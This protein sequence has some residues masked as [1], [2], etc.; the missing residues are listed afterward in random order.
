MFK[1]FD[2]LDKK[3]FLILAI[4]DKEGRYYKRGHQYKIK[5]WRKNTVKRKIVLIIV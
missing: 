5:V 4:E 2:F 1:G 3:N